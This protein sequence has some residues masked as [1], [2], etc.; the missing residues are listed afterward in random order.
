MLC[1]DR[2]FDPLPPGRVVQGFDTVVK[3]VEA[4]GSQSGTPKA[5]VVIA[6]S[7]IC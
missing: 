4:L 6:R 1:L 7:G 5:Q 3:K 2:T